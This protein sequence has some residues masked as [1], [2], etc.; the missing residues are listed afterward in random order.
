MSLSYISVNNVK[1]IY[2]KSVK[3]TQSKRKKKKEKASSCENRHWLATYE[4][5]LDN[6]PVSKL[7][8]ACAPACFDPTHSLNTSHTLKLK[9][10]PYVSVLLKILATV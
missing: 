1:N 3:H 10:L 5:K 2:K 6:K 4:K 9:E 8:E 7:C